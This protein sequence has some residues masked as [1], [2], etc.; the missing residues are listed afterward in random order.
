M[1]CDGGTGGQAFLQERQSTNLAHGNASQFT[2][3]HKQ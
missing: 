3:P 2:E 1:S